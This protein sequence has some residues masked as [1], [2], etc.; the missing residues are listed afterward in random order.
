MSEMFELASRN[1][2]RF[3]YKGWLATEDL[4]DLGVQELDGIFKKLNATLKATK[5]E[6]LLGPKTQADTDLELQV[7]IVR[8]VVEVKLAEATARELEAGKKEKKQVI[9]AIKA[10]KQNE[11]LKNMSVED[12]DKLLDAL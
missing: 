3:A 6:S 11:I 8:H 9:L 1:K 2:I 7:A 12:L 5:E 4:W 10:D